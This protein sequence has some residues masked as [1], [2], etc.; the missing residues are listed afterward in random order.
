MRNR[1]VLIGQESRTNNELFQMLNWRFLVTQYH[2]VDE[3]PME[4]V[5]LLKPKLFIINLE[6]TTGNLAGLLKKIQERFATVPLVTIGM[7]SESDAYETFYATGRVHKVLRPVTGKRFVEICRAV[8]AGESYAK[9]AQEGVKRNGKQHILI[10]DDNA[11]VLRNIKGILE[12]RYSAAVAPSG[13]HGFVSIGKQMPDLILLDYEMPEMNGKEFL[14]KLQAEPEFAD[15]PVV[16]LTS[17]DSKEIVMELLALRPA[18]YIL[19]PVD[20]QMLLDK[21]EGIIGK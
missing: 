19:K 1:I 10:V 17:M 5:S 8:I 21:I 7:K 6:G 18:G 14:E 13:L 15:I 20:S 4:E 3:V 11:M 2:N 16:F 12:Q 9:I